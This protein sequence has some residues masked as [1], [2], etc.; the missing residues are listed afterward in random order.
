MPGYSVPYVHS[1]DPGYAPPVLRAPSPTD[2][3]GTD[4]GPDETTPD[5]ERLSD[6]EFAKI[7]QQRLRLGDMRREEREAEADP[8]LQKPKN[9]DEERRASA[10]AWLLVVMP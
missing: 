10:I 4:Y 6:A 2:S 8:L 3:I 5:E 1:G 7:C 9:P